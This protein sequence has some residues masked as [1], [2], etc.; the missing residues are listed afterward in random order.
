MFSGKADT[1]H[2]LF[3]VKI[4]LNNKFKSSPIHLSHPSLCLFWGEGTLLFIAWGITWGNYLSWTCSLQKFA[5]PSSGEHT[6][7]NVNVGHSKVILFL[8]LS[9]S[10]SMITE[11][12]IYSFYLFPVAT[13]W[14]L[15][16]PALVVNTDIM[17][18]TYVSWSL[19]VSCTIWHIYG[20]SWYDVNVAFKIEV[21][22]IVLCP[23][24][25]RGVFASYPWLC[26]VFLCVLVCSAPLRCVRWLMLVCF[27]FTVN[28]KHWTVT[29]VKW[30][31]VSAIRGT[32]AASG[33]DDV[34]I[35]W[36]RLPLE[37]MRSWSKAVW[38]R[39]G[40]WSTDIKHQTS[41]NVQ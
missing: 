35:G 15:N 21:L 28:T 7:Y 32:K 20:V 14:R 9:L 34:L 31:S 19:A 29:L 23:S 12:D 6:V 26:V 8:S 1:C 16:R 10:P 27:Q 40:P 18:L 25:R 2:V 39:R 13:S 5:L 24:E 3:F 38:T 37:K 4:A 41:E 17:T 11:H 22:V 33:E 36:Q 30:C